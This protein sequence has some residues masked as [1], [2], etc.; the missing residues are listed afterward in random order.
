[1]ALS[2]ERTAIVLAGGPN[3][4]IS[5]LAPGA[6]NKAFVPIAGVTLA[7]RTVDALRS[8]PRVGRVVAVAP[9]VPVALAELYSADEIRPA[10]ATMS[11]SLRAGLA[12]FPPAGLVLVAASDL[13]ILS[14]AAIEEF[15]D[16]AER[17]GADLVYA[18]V[19]RSAHERRF[20]EMPHTWA[21][22]RDGTFCGGG[23]VAMRP[24]AFEKLDRFLGRL[25][26]ARKNPL[27][28][29]SIFGYDVLLRYA[30]RRLTV[31]DAERRATRLLGLPIAA[32][33]CT[34]PEIA[35]N[36]DRVSDIA[37]VESVIRRNRDGQ[38][39]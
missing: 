23:L 16:I 33:L 2:A 9:L 11:L 20:P 35:V 7:R 29:A 30:L 19:E 37:L 8:T 25:G 31:A 39:G 28:L 27:H 10:G 21:H 24:R 26:A 38:R 15:L 22:L 3:D 32:A 36:V 18:C 12:G 13:P 6:P 14:A 34:H 1:M 5:A 17:S 4:E